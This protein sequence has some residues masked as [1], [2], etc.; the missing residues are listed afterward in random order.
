MSKTSLKIALQQSII[1]G[2][3]AIGTYLHQMG[4]PVGTSIEELNLTRPEVVEQVHRRYIEAGARLIETNTFAANR[5]KLARFGLEEQVEAINKAG[6]EL[7]LKA[8]A[9]SG[10]DVYVTAA[11]GSIRSGKRSLLAIEELSEI[12]QEQLDVLLS[13]PIDGIILESFLELEELLV[14]LRA[15]RKQSK[16]PVICQLAADD[17]G[18]TVDGYTVSDAFR[19]LLDEGADVVGFNCRSGPYGILRAM[20]K[21]DPIPGAVYSVFPNAGIPD[22]VDG[23]LTYAASPEYFAE[24][25]HRFAD[26]GARLIGGCCGTTPEHISSIS[27][28]IETYVPK[29]KSQESEGIQV[30]VE[31]KVQA[32]QTAEA[33]EAEPARKP[34][35][36]DLA[37]QRYT[38][39][40]ELDPPRGL[41]YKKFM[42]GVEAL[43]AV[44]V[45]AITMADNPKAVTRMSNVPLGYMAQ[46]QY[47]ARPLLHIACRDRNL[48]GMQ[49]HLMGL[50]ALGID[51]ILAITG[52][53]VSNG[54][55][56]QAKSVFDLTSTE[57]IRMIKQLN[58]G[59]AFS[60]Q[61]LKKK[62][63]FVVGGALPN[64]K[65]IERGVQ[66]LEKKI[67]AGADFIMTQCVYDHAQIEKLAECSKHL[68][69][70]IF[71]G[72]MPLANGRNAEFLHNEMP[73]ITVP[74]EVRRRMA[75]LEGIEGRQEGMEIAKEL[76]DTAMKHFNGI[77]LVTPFMSYEVTVELT[78]YVWEKAGR[79]SPA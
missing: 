42:E 72:I 30:S 9:A 77:Y 53:P 37:K 26:L 60:G 62:A 71:I 24:Y 47:G 10:K 35:I 22:Y 14:A 3:G 34:N 45:D 11:V 15:I 48:I 65:H 52:D 49:S 73:G 25:A 17:V 39:V 2:D 1:V 56:P 59:I 57:V 7:A 23:Q 21:M 64:F 58:E 40:V 28:A 41:S 51:H 54:D 61:P 46:E 36:V 27:S 12:Y 38:V 74:D 70:P 63:N 8:A 69:V 4:F 67:E 20:E 19:K 50:D 16:L 5:E 32:G 55:L 75:G 33:R 68:E 6:V 18:R 13:T 43:Q 76:I 44:E 66:R 29:V 78:K 79:L 31:S